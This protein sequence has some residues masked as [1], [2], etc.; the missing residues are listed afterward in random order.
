MFNLAS[1]QPRRIGDI[2]ATMIARASVPIRVE[3][4]LARL[5]CASVKR[6]FLISSAPSGWADSTSR[7]GRFRGAGHVVI[8]EAI[9]V[10]ILDPLGWNH[11][12][13]QE[14]PRPRFWITCD[15]WSRVERPVHY[16]NSIPAA[17]KKFEVF[18]R[19]AS[20]HVS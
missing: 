1:G 15:F 5:G 4:D 3:V 18:V 13:I 7:R 6:L 17:S 14:V 19:A 10:R 9:R 11:P 12:N 16:E 20:G 8:P 2:L